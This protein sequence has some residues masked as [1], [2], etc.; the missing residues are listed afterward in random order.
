[1]SSSADHTKLATLEVL[2]Q[3]RLLPSAS[4]LACGLSFRIVPGADVASALRRTRD[5]FSTAWGVLG[6]GEPLSR[7][8]SRNVAGLRTFPALSGPAGSVPSTQHAL[9]IYLHADDRGALFDRSRELQA[10]LAPAL[11]LTDAQDLFMYAGGRDLT[12]YEDG[13]E[14]PKGDDAVTAA[15]TAEGDGLRGGSFVAVQRWLHD[16][17]GF[18][19]RPSSE[20]DDVIGRRRDDNVELGDAP[21]SA[22]VKRSA[23]ESFEP[24]AFMLRRSM[25]WASAEAQGL[26]FIAYGESLDRFERVLRRMLGLE[27]GVV[28]ALFSFSRPLTGAYYFCPPVDRGKL[29]LRCLG[30]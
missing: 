3:P 6:V 18:N 15:L 24:P 26:E 23:Q 27:D 8:L 13:T 22:H 4:P 12:G 25:P 11:V 30:L 28:D 20:R 7:A 1:M 5:G 2:V 29:D 14:N 17:K 21:K 9:W 10:L 19:A 16:L